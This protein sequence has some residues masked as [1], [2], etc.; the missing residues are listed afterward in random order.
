MQ[1]SNPKKRL[2]KPQHQNR[3]GAEYKMEPPP[4]YDDVKV[5]GSGKLLDK[6]ALI[7]G[8]DS[9]IGRA[10]AILFSKEGAGIAVLYLKEHKDAEETKKRV[11]A[12]G[13]KCLLITADISKEKN[14]ISA[15]EK[16]YKKFGRIDILVNY[17]GVHEESK[18]LE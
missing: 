4:V 15:V 17:A 7:S 2:R 13:R 11:E 12:Y 14:C 1:R 3:P 6:V 9:G 16:T 5:K 18:G 8:G 10:V